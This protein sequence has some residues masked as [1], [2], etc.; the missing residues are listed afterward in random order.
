MF[1]VRPRHMQCDLHCRE[2]PQQ[3]A[4]DV[5]CS[6]RAAEA[7]ERNQLWTK[8]LIA[9]SGS[10]AGLGPACDSLHS[11]HDVL[12]YVHPTIIHPIET[13]WWVPLLFGLAGAILGVGIPLL[14][15]ALGT[16]EAWG[17]RP[18]SRVGALPLLSRVLML[19][20]RR[21]SACALV[22]ELACRSTRAA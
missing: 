2:R 21:H 6:A 8:Q 20:C 9:S 3:H 22:C 18:P 19:W 10:G 5:L 16:G 12:H 17:T 14:D 1:T 11:S 13:C 15:D 7:S 4:R